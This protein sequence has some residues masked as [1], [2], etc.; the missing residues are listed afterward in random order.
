LENIDGSIVSRD[1]LIK[2]G[3]KARRLW[4]SLVGAG[5]APSSWGK[6]G[7]NVYNYF[8]SEML[9]VPD[10]EFLRYCKGNWK[11]MRWT[12]KAYASWKHNHF[13]TAEAG[14]TVRTNKRKHELLD[15]PSLLQLED[16]KNEDCAPGSSSDSSPVDNTSGSSTLPATSASTLAHIQVQYAHFTYSDTW[17]NNDNYQQPPITIVDPLYVNSIEYPSTLTLLIAKNSI[18]KSI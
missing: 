16:D 15:D 17:L 8:I 2:V 3:Q 5:L 4:Q 9:S 1:V 10:F 12:T 13:D 7:E 18:M 14:K 6:A 11:L